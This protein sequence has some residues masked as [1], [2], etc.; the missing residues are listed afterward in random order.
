MKVYGIIIY[1]GG[2]T[3]TKVKK[4]N[5]TDCEFQTLKSRK[6]QFVNI[7]ISEDK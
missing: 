3:L 5:Y 7:K 4:N 1:D 6:S 2:Y